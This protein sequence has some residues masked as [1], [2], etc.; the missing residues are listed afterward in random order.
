MST[1]NPD[2]WRTAA[3][4]I[5]LPT[6]AAALR[7]TPTTDAQRIARAATGITAD[8]APQ[9]LADQLDALCD[10]DC[11]DYLVPAA[12][13]RARCRDLAEASGWIHPD[14]PVA[15]CVDWARFAAL[16][17]ADASTVTLNGTRHYLD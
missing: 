7:S 17:A 5:H 9:A 4:Y 12:A 11:V 8:L 6:V 3:G 13:W 16:R 14:S 10:N 1:A 15:R 2:T